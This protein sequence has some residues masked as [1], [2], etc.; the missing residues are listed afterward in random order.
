MRDLPQ[1]VGKCRVVEPSHAVASGSG[2]GAP[3]HGATRKSPRASFKALPLSSSHFPWVVR[4]PRSGLPCPARPGNPKG[5]RGVR[6]PCA[7]P[8]T[9]MKGD[10]TPNAARRFQAASASVVGA[11]APGPARKYIRPTPCNLPNGRRERLQDRAAAR[12]ASAKRT[13]ASGRATERSASRIFARA[14]ASAAMSAM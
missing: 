14:E 7:G 3:K 13:A 11:P 4:V 9:E 10:S 2:T 12:M 8:P 5:C 1:G 6:F